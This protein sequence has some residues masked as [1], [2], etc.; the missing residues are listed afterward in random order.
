MNCKPGIGL[1]LAVC[2]QEQRVANS[3]GCSST[4]LR[5][6]RASSL[7]HTRQRLPGWTTSAGRLPAA[8]RPQRHAVQRIFRVARTLVEDWRALCMSNVCH[9]AP[10][11]CWR[12]CSLV[13]RLRE[14]VGRRV[15][16]RQVAA[17][18]CAE[19]WQLAVFFRL[20]HNSIVHYH[21]CSIK[22]LTSF[23]QFW[24]RLPLCSH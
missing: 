7:V 6:L 4:G 23:Y 19:H 15:S 11:R 12:V 17:L 9:A 13:Q 21:V 18:V 8:A 20:D 22:K 10:A 3:V 1:K 14:L 2:F 16:P 24:I 5:G